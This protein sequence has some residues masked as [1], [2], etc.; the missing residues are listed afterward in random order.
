MSQTKKTKIPIKPHTNINVFRILPIFVNINATP[1]P[2]NAP[3]K[4]PEIPIIIK[5][6]RKTLSNR[7]DISKQ[8]AINPIIAPSDIHIGN[9]RSAYFWIK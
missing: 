9:I 4:A 5:N 7:S 8:K 3:P 2:A 1:N 6:P